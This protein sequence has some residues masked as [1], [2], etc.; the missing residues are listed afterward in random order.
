MRDAGLTKALRNL[1]WRVKEEGDLELVIPQREDPQVTIRVLV[2][3][4]IRPDHYSLIVFIGA[5]S[6]AATLI[7]DITT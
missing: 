7:R 4:Q 5:M 2:K 1:D 3:V 6:P